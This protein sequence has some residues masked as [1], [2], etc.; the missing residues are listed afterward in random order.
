V[1]AN[2]ATNFAIGGAG[3]H[4]VTSLGFNLSNNYNGVITPLATD[5]TT[6]APRLGPLSLGG[7]PTPT[8]A[9]LGGSPALNTG[10]SSGQR[11]INAATR[12]RLPTPISAR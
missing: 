11:R 6:V 10:N 1:I 7:G 12:V 3:F 5:I 2:N 8:H 4:I 9:L